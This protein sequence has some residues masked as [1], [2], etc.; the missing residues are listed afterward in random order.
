[1]KIG[2]V[3]DIHEDYE[4]LLLAY[5]VLVSHNCSYF[6]C[7]GDITGYTPDYY[8]YPQTHSAAK[9]IHFVKSN[10]QKVIAGNH[11]FHLAG[12]TPDYPGN[13]KVHPSHFEIDIK[14]RKEYYK[15]QIWLYTEESQDND[16]ED[17]DIQYLR[18]LSEYE[19]L[20]T[21]E[22]NLLFS[23]Y[24]FPNLSGFTKEL[25]F[26]K[27]EMVKHFEFMKNLNVNISFSGHAH[28]EGALLFS[29]GKK[30][31]IQKGTHIVNRDAETIIV[32]PTI[33]NGKNRQYVMTFNTENFAFE[34]IPFSTKRKFLKIFN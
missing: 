6:V 9:C 28:V 2:F 11:D 31:F 23:H 16:L 33:A 12:K 30:R 20:Q 27:N 29:N 7:L 15:D 18:N 32:G 24:I 19:T 34:T 5:E 13:I 21:K 25:F 3:S 10:F 4:S 22:T 14:E 8:H 1:M 26:R 17:N